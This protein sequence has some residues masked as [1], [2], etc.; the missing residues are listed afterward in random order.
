MRTSNPTMAQDWLQRQ[1]YVLE[2]SNPLF[3]L[4]ELVFH[5]IFIFRM[6]PDLIL[7]NSGL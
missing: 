7:A 4:S 5:R 1:A 6:Q 2:L 3:L